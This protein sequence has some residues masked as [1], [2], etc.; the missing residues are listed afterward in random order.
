MGSTHTNWLPII[1]L[2]TTSL[3]G[4]IGSGS[5]RATHKAA[6]EVFEVPSEEPLSSGIV[7]YQ[8]LSG[9]VYAFEPELTEEADASSFDR[10]SQATVVDGQAVLSIQTFG[11][12][13]YGGE[14]CS[15]PPPLTGSSYLF[16]VD[17][18][19]ESE[20]L[21]VVLTPGYSARGELF[22]ITVTSLE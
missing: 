11:P 14:A 22:A 19:T 21:T 8:P 20:L 10:N 18:E 17:S 4:C 7:I 5:T 1:A 16:R 15:P 2:L 13:C 9:P 6:I 3:T 12:P